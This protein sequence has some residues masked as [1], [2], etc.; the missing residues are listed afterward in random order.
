LQLYCAR[1]V[2]EGLIEAA[3]P[4]QLDATGDPCGGVV[5]TYL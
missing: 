5:R 3:K 1:Q 2:L 4:A